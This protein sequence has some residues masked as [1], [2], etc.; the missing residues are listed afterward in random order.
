MSYID[1]HEPQ[2][3][4]SEELKRKWK[5]TQYGRDGYI[6]MWDVDW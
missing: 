1:S 3:W 6:A 2:P 4:I 5:G